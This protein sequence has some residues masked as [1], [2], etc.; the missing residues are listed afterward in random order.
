MD[1]L[2]ATALES[3]LLKESRESRNRALAASYTLNLRS[4]VK[5]SVYGKGADANTE[6]WRS[7]GIVVRLFR[8]DVPKSGS[9]R[10]FTDGTVCITT[11]DAIPSKFTAN[12]TQITYYDDEMRPVLERAALDGEVF[13][14]NPPLF[15]DKLE[16][17]RKKDKKK[18]THHEAMSMEKFEELS[19]ENR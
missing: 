15:E 8:K 17:L 11:A 2:R 18:M 4:V 12:H 13:S 7:S 3:R 19:K 14:Y 10:V 6:L 9:P 1:A 5:V 16:S